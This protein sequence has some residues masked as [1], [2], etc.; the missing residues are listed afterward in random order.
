MDNFKVKWKQIKNF[1]EDFSFARFGDK[2]VEVIPVE[3]QDWVFTI[4][5]SDE[6]PSV[7]CD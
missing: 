2:M 1:H 6:W 4:F 7:V 5:Y 3:A